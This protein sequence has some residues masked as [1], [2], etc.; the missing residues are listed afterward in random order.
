MADRDLITKL[1]GNRW[2][3]TSAPSAGTTVNALVSAPV[4]PQARHHLELL[5][6][7]IHNRTGSGN[8]PATVSV[9]V[10]HASQQGTVIA[11]V[12]HLVSPSSTANVSISNMGIAG[13]RGK[14][15]CATMSTVVA[16]LTQKVNIAGWTEE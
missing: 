2:S 6:Y 10:R 9:Q 16:S 14:A 13:K 3:N 1:L 12:D 15:I 5:W 7:S 8:V 4:A 11:Q